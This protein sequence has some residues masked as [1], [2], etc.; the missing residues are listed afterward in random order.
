MLYQYDRDN[1]L[2]EEITMRPGMQGF[3]VFDK[4]GNEDRLLRRTKGSFPDDHDPVEETGTI[5]LDSLGRLVKNV[6]K[7]GYIAYLYN[8]ACTDKVTQTWSYGNNDFLYNK[9]SFEY[10]PKCLLRSKTTI[11]FYEKLDYGPDRRPDTTQTFFTY[12]SNGN[13]TEEKSFR[14]SNELLYQLNIKYNKKIISEV[15]LIDNSRHKRSL[16]NFNNKAELL[17]L[18]IFID[19]KL[20]EDNFYSYEYDEKGNWIKRIC[21]DK[22]NKKKVSVIERSIVYAE[23]PASGLR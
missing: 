13:I 18:K 8:S 15:I 23:T 16:Y 6:W 10:D 5:V 19:N 1:N 9:T 7:N 21:D 12:N 2:A 4:N 14:S 22:V 17:S 11:S 3:F 20:A